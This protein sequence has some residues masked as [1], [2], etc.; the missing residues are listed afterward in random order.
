MSQRQSLKAAL[1]VFKTDHRDKQR[2]VDTL[3]LRVAEAEESLADV[4]TTIK[5]LEQKIAALGPKGPYGKFK[6]SPQAILAYLEGNPFAT[7]PEIV[8][9]LLAGGFQT[10]SDKFREV[11]RIALQRLEQRG[12]VEQGGGGRWALR[13]NR[14][15]VVVDEDHKSRAGESP[16]GTASPHAAPR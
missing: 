14:S 1:A 2:V 7:I 4:A 16:D 11:V 5:L 6:T 12:K 3:R 10:T 13:Y 8:D 9:G 15:Y